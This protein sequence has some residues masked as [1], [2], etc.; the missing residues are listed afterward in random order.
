MTPKE[1]LTA[2]DLKMYL[3]TGLKVQHTTMHEDIAKHGHI[4]EICEIEMIGNECVTFTGNCCDFYFD[5]N[6]PDCEIKPILIPLS[7]LTKEELR[8]QGFSSHIDYLT[9]EKQ[10]PLKAPFEMVQYLFTNHFDIYGLIDKGLAI[11]VTNEFNP[12]SK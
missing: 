1:K 8:E 5:D 10:N 7:D 9:H 12:Y 6:E 11:A 3:G 2:N 4:D